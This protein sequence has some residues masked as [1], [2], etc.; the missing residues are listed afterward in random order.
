MIFLD[1]NYHPYYSFCQHCFIGVNAS[2][3][4]FSNPAENIFNAVT[5]SA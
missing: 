4:F 3:R 5:P 1:N 2:G